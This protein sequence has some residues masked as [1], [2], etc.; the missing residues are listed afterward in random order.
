MH[1]VTRCFAIGCAAAV[2]AGAVLTRAQTPSAPAAATQA[3]AAQPV[4]F[5]RD[6]QPIFEQYCYECHGSAKARGK[7]RLHA[8]QFIRKGGESG[9][10][11]T[12]CKSHDS[13]LIRRLLEIGRA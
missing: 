3:V 10:A 5:A 9:P 2:L 6:I 8:P 13:R 12:P 1:R 7:L 11:I 4:D